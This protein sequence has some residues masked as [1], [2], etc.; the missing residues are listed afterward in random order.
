M[1]KDRK[2][3]KVENINIVEVILPC[4]R[5]WHARCCCMHC[6]NHLTL[7]REG[8]IQ[9]KGTQTSTHEKGELQSYTT[10]YFDFLECGEQRLSKL[11]LCFVP[12]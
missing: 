4:T 11:E 1:K 9:S 2:D 10:I 5:Y 12:T 7:L 6:V 8:C 3:I